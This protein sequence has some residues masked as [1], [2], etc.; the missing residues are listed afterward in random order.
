MHWTAKQKWMA[1]IL[2]ISLAVLETHARRGLT[3]HTLLAAFIGLC[4]GFALGTM[5]AK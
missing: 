2:S 3:W 4:V 5:E 1:G